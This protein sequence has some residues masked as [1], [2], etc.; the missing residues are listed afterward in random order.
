MTHNLRI[1]CAE[2]Y[3]HNVN[4]LRPNVGLETWIWRQIVTSQT[5]YIKYKWPPY[6]TEWNLAV[7]IFFV[8]HWTRPT[9]VPRRLSRTQ[10]VLGI[11]IPGGCWH[12][13]RGWKC[14]VL[15]GCPRIPHSIGDPLSA[16]HLSCHCQINWW[17]S[18]YFGDARTSIN[19]L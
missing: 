17:V 15:W 19:K 6:A 7:K 8:R 9:P 12:R 16:P 3:L 14:G 18:F 2:E 10:A 1:V 13:C 5:T 4:N 11:I